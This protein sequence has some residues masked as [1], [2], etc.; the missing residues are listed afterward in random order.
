MSNEPTIEQIDNAFS[1]TLRVLREEIATWRVTANRGRTALLS[2]RHIIVDALDRAITF[3]PGE[4]HL[5]Q[6]P[7]DLIGVSFLTLENALRQVEAL[8]GMFLTVHDAFEYANQ[9]AVKAE[10]LLNTLVD[11]QARRTR[12]AEALAAAGGNPARAARAQD[13]HDDTSLRAR[14]LAAVVREMGLAAPPEGSKSRDE[15][16]DRLSHAVSAH[17]LAR[18]E[19]LSDGLREALQEAYF[20]SE[21]DAGAY[22]PGWRREIVINGKRGLGDESDAALLERVM[23]NVGHDY[24]VGP[25]GRWFGDNER[26]FLVVMA[27]AGQ[28]EMVR[29]AI[30][31][32]IHDYPLET[33]QALSQSYVA[34][35]LSDPYESMLRELEQAPA[36]APSF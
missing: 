16:A 6:A 3:R 33:A 27:Q 11:K 2:E 17:S 14:V 22:G 24:L 23:M 34:L 21:N 31:E 5:E 25:D 12:D 29:A 19:L 36:A 7:P 32:E 26:E 9:R 28:V 1:D 8:P 4:Y 10:R 15:L 35:G 13:A 30:V 18:I 20:Q